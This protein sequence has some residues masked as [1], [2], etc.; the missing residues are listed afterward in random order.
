MKN[1]TFKLSHSVLATAVLLLVEAALFYFGAPK[2]IQEVV[3]LGVAAIGAVINI[4]VATE[5]IEEVKGRTHMFVILT[6][7][8]IQFIL[9]FAFEYFFL[10]LVQPASFPNLTA[11]PVTFVLHSV[12][13]FVFNPLYLPA[14]AA[15]RSLL[16]INT[17][18]ALGLALFV[19]QN[20]SQFRAKSLD[21]VK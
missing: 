18:G 8:M 12:M 16:L 3:V 4:Y 1:N 13:V 20:I 6:I 11:D 5:V 15:G 7:V 10:Y 21:K 2:S 9:F 19:L 17:F 14:T